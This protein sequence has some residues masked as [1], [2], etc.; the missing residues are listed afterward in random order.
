MHLT[1]TREQPKMKRQITIHDEMNR[2][3]DLEEGKYSEFL[4]AIGYLSTWALISNYARVDIYVM[5]DAELTAIYHR[6]MESDTTK[7]PD[8]VIGAIYDHENERYSFHS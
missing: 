4:R 1:Q 6:S 8:Y 3:E 2:Y 7:G 5:A